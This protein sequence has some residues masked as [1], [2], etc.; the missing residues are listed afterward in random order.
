VL[1]ADGCIVSAGYVDMQVHL[2]EPGREEAAT[3][4]PGSRAAALW[5][6][7][8]VIAMHNTT[9]CLDEP[10]VVAW[11]Q[12]RGREV[13]LCDVFASAAITVG[14]RGERLVDMAA[15]F[16]VGV[17]LSPTTVMWSWTQRSFAMPSW[18]RVDSLGRTSASTPKISAL[19][20]VATCMTAPS[21]APLALPGGP[22]WRRK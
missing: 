18:R 21:P 11:V 9:P 20:G 17:R 10:E 3:I 6:F 8:A 13:G 1:N 22:P 4:E 16:A 14:R 7:T 5:G 12:Q 2:R 15:L 19:S